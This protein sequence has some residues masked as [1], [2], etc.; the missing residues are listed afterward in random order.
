VKRWQPVLAALLL[1]CSSA[2]ADHERLG[3]RSYREGDFT[4]AIA[5]Y[6]AALRSGGSAQVWA[7]LGSAALREHQ[8]GTAVE[9]FS[10]LRQEDP[11]RATEAAIGL[12]RAAE[13]AER[14]GATEVIHLAAAVRALRAIPGRPL[15]RWALTPNAELGPT[16][17]IGALPAMLASASS[18]RVVDS[19][20]VLYGEAQRATTACEAA[21][22]TYRTI[23][24][25]NSLAPQRAA[26]GS[27]LGACGLRLGLDALRSSQGDLAE[28]WLESAIQAVPSSPVGWRAEI[29]LGDARL[30]QGDVLGAA[31]AYQGVLSIKGIPDSLHALARA[32][33]DSLG[34][35]GPVPGAG[36]KSPGG[37]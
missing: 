32:K 11:S 14:G 10:A 23:L 22:R 26:A 33:L 8:L 31:L 37:Q 27:G 25:R 36:T 4:V 20:L 6:R 12:E 1:G 35:S 9:A 30:L 28:H 3:D 34:S 15:G 17:A 5:E 19:L 18:A 2:A 13:L 24:R 7:K 29:G 16:E 21:I